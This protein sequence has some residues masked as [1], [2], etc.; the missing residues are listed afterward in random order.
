M[1]WSIPIILLLSLPFGCAKETKPSPPPENN[2]PEV[3]SL[4]TRP[5][6]VLA[7][8]GV[9]ASCK[10]RDRDKEY[11]KFWWDASAGEFPSGSVL[12]TVAWVSPPR[13]GEQT[14][15]VWVTDFEDTTTATLPV[16]VVRVAAPDSI[17]FVNGSNL[18]SIGWG[19]AAD[20]SVEHWSGYE[21][22]AGPR[23]LT[24]APPETLALYRRTPEPLGRLQYRILSV[25]PGR[26]LFIHVRSRRDYEGVV[27]RSEAGP[28]ID[29]AARLDGFGNATLYEVASRRGARGV[30]L[31]GGT[32]EALDPERIDRI[33]LYMGTSDPADGPGTLW[34][35]SPSE[36]DYRDPSWA[37]RVTGLQFL[38][39][40][41]DV[42][43]PSDAPMVRKTPLLR[44]AV[45][46]LITADD[47]YA[48]FQVLEIH[49]TMPERRIEFQWA[50]QPLE[51]YPRF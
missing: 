17:G 10:A 4:E 30:H 47:H 6:R 46:A 11:M 7:S 48:K 20:A 2:A 40:E 5:Q 34:L 29:T 50:W 13:L 36:L 26:K 44:G 15:R 38:G 21:V 51:G 31:P 22:F 33:D 25:T 42:A 3:L 37:G 27:E 9:F 19:A 35:K 41:W 43:V 45:Y 18:V 23:S 14:L 39:Y 24:D 32:V 1:R 49:G 8:Q 12:S 16:D 28:E